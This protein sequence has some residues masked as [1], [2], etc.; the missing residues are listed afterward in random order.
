[1]EEVFG[2]PPDADW[3][4]LAHGQTAEEASS[5]ART[6]TGVTVE[7]ALTNIEIERA[8]KLKRKSAQNM[9]AITFS[10]KEKRA[11]FQSQA[12]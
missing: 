10:K 2:L 5:L 11:D 9:G 12:K 1:M 3:A 6:L 7:Q 8:G 4:W